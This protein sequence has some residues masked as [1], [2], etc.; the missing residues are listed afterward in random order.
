VTRFAI[1]EG[2]T[3]LAWRNGGE[4][5]LVSFRGDAVSLRSSVPWPPGSRVE[6]T[7]SAPPAALLRI[8]VHACKRH[9]DGSYVMSGRMLD[10]TRALRERLEVLVAPEGRRTPS[11]Q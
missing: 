2:V 11:P 7:L 4:A 9:E 5:T 3:H 1:P 8:K 6:G 10:L